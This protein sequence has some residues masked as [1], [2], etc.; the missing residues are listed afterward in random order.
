M[1]RIVTAGMSPSI[2]KT[3]VY[4]ILEL[5]EVNRST[6]YRLDASGKAYNAARVLNQLS[7]G[8]AVNLSPLGEENALQFLRLA[9][10]DSVPV[11]HS[12]VPG[13]VRS[14]YTLLEPS[15]GRTTELVVDEPATSADY[16]ALSEKFYHLCKREMTGAQAFL[17]AGSR[18]PFWPE[19]LYPRICQAARQEG[20]LTMVDF[21][22]KDLLET[23]FVSI[24]SII[25]INEAEYCETFACPNPLNED[26]LER[27]LADR[28]REFGLSLLL[29]EGLRIRL[30]LKAVSYFASRLTQSP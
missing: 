28:S 21:R 19:D 12:T 26:R 13:S 20:I 11:V 27:E 16:S 25:K 5:G 29:P 17:V 8:S 7:P 14:C 22:G 9:E 23:L 6:G 15:S 3:M 10:G 18:P 1:T 4:R 2:Q 30:Q 24:P